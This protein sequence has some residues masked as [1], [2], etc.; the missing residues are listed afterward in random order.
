MET[1]FCAGFLGTHIG[2]TEIVLILA[3]VLLLFGAT[4][5]PEVARSLGK[6][7]NEFK[8]GIKG[9]EPGKDDPK[10]LEG[11]KEQGGGGA[12]GA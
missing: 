6:G 1:A 3:I 11:G 12:K 5:I 8:K 9:E 10:A 4:R 2:V 7:V